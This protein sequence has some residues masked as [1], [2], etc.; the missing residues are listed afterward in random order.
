MTSATWCTLAELAMAHHA[1][2]L[3]G[4]HLWSAI[5]YALFS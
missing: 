1:H 4:P 3:R 2:T 5:I